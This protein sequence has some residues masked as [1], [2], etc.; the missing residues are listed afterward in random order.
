[1]DIRLPGQDGY[2]AAKQIR[3]F[4]KDAVIF[5]QTA[6]GLTGDREKAL[7]S[8]CNDYLSKLINRDELS[9][10]ILRYRGKFRR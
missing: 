3:E 5:A 9:K 10:M 8:G 6:Y 2:E 7:E 1:M 4:N